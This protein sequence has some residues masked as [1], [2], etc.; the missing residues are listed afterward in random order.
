MKEEKR[1]SCLFQRIFI[2]IREKKTIYS[3]TNKSPGCLLAMNLFI[4][5]HIINHND[6]VDRA[7]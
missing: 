1:K 2:R 6:Q 7:L 5:C 4:N 3:I